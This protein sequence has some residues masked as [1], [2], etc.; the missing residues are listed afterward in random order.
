[1][2]FKKDKIKSSSNSIVMLKDE[3]KIIVAKD[4]TDKYIYFNPDNDN[5]NGDIFNY[6]SNRGIK[7]YKDM[8]ETLKNIDMNI[9]IPELKIKGTISS[10]EDLK[11]V[12]EWHNYEQKENCDY[13]Y[14]TDTRLIKQSIVEAY[15][16]LLKADKQGNI[17]VPLTKFMEDRI[18]KYF[19]I[20]GYDRK[21]KNPKPNQAKSYINGRK[22]VCILAP[23]DIGNAENVVIGE[24]YIDCLSYIQLHHLNPHKTTILSTQGTITKTELDTIKAIID[25][26]ARRIV[27]KKIHLAFDEDRKGKEY[28]MKTEAMIIRETEYGDKII[29][30]ELA[31]YKDWN[32]KLVTKLRIKEQNNQQPTKKGRKKKDNGIDF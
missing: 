19:D 31:G 15:N 29:K 3:E 28:F 10:A 24:S 23:K 1:M 27:L 2:G 9:E 6:L 18:G 17:I 8:Q 4:K 5:D 20:M 16:H 32:E 25:R 26:T 12:A 13:S 21:L 14:L 30:K 11:A 7:S 22:G